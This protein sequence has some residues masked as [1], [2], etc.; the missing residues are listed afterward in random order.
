MTK[1][2]K[3]VE[4]TGFTK[5]SSLLPQIKKADKK[6]TPVKNSH[7]ETNDEITQNDQITTSQATADDESTT[8]HELQTETNT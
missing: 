6:H 3:Q 4:I 7:N 1:R 5:A 8:R 2:K